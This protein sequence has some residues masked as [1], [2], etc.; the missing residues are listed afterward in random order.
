M[1]RDP[2]FAADLARYPDRAFLR[3][4]SIWAIYIYRFG[5]RVRNRKP[6]FIRSVQLKVYWLFF[7][8]IETITGISLPL[9]TQIGPG[10]RIYHFGNIFV[11]NEA[12]LGRNC[13]LRHGVTIGNRVEDG[14]SP[15]IG[16]DVEFGAY[17]QVLGKVRIGNGAKIG[18]MS[19][20]LIDVPPGATAFGVPAR[21]LP[22]GTVSRSSV[23]SVSS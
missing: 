19:V 21:V 22:R 14:P 1:T 3:E 16:D 23:A 13:T 8:L 5:R 18:A 11:H 17:A 20:V 10:L 9:E 6:G 12:V 2:D 7:R 15:V 4:Q